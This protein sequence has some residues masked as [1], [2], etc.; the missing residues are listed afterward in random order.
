MGEVAPG[1]EAM[2]Q[3]LLE[4]FAETVFQDRTGGNPPIQG[5]HREAVII[6]KTRGSTGKT[7]H[8]SN[9]QRKE[10]GLG[11]P[12]NQIPKGKKTS[13][14]TL[15]NQSVTTQGVGSVTAGSQIKFLSENFPVTILLWGWGVFSYPTLEPLALNSVSHPS[16]W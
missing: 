9:A 10:N 5:L 15:K 2:R 1:V 7:R 16:G 3:K 11:R 12:V 14:S 13:Q 6:L 8:V 4:E